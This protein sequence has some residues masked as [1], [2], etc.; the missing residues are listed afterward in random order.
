MQTFEQN[1]TFFQIVNIKFYVLA[2]DLKR[3]TVDYWNV[4]DYF[5]FVKFK[6]ITELF[7]VLLV[8]G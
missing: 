3:I 5:V 7:Y 2:Y 4:V 6:V 1:P 8:L